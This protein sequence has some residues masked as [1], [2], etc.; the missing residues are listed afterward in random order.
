MATLTGEQLK[1]SYQSLVTIGDSITS[2]PTV[3]ALENGKGTLLS[4]VGVGTNSPTGLGN[5]IIEVFNGTDTQLVLRN[6][7]NFGT[8]F[9]GA[10]VGDPTS[11]FSNVGFKFAIADDKNATNFSEKMRIKSTGD[12]SFR[13]GSAN[14]AFYWDASEARLGIGETSPAEQLHITASSGY[15]NLRLE[16]STGGGGIQYYN[17]VTKL[18]DILINPA[19]DILFR[20]TSE[21]MRIDSSGNVG[22]GTDSPTTALDVAGTITSDGL[23]VSEGSSG[24]TANTNADAIVI[25]NNDKTG[26]SILTPNTS[27][28][29]IFFADPE[30]DNIGRIAYNHST[31]AMSLVTNNNTRLTI[32][33]SGNVGIGT[34]PDYRLSIQGSQTAGYAL[35]LK[36]GN[37]NDAIRFYLD[38]DTGTSNQG[39][40]IFLGDPS[41]GTFATSVSID[42]RL[43]NNSYFNNGGN[44]GIGTTSPDVELDVDGEI[45]ASDG[46]LFGTDTAAANALDDYE[47]GNTTATFTATTSGTITANTALD[48]IEYTKIGDICHVQGTVYIDSVASPVGN[49]QINCLPFLSKSIPETADFLTANVA[50]YDGSTYSQKESIIGPNNQ[51]I[52]VYMDASTLV[53]TDRFFIQATYKA[54]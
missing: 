43:N 4:G 3:G 41:S 46:I 31:D 34:N 42:S 21:A 45:R 10:T 2:N 5:A 48:R 39:S 24:A 47:E 51:Y 20:N 22:I 11:V 32:D 26:L 29:L 13:D 8:I 30:D 25:E 38:G 53:A 54:V 36:S 49:V 23:T 27:E 6:N 1:D 12:V 52:T 7:N 18:G 17:G 14:E 28:G 37:G 35:N 44:V 19:Q 40:A 50:F 15:A 16:G 9:N 33:S